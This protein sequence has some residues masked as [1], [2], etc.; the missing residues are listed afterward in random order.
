[1]TLNHLRNKNLSEWWTIQHL[2]DE[3]LNI[4]VQKKHTPNMIKNKISLL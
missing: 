1:M 4:M 2:E 3:T